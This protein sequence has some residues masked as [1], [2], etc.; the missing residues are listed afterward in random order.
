LIVR[1]GFDDATTGSLILLLAPFASYLPAEH[2]R[3]SG[4][5]AAVATGIVLSRRSRFFIGPETRMQSSSTW[6]LLTFILNGF[7]FLLIGL[8][9]PTIVA[10]LEPHVRDYA[11]TAAVLCAVVIVVRLA[12]VAL[13]TAV[14]HLRPGRGP[15]TSWAA[16][17]V[18]GW[19]G[20]RGIV[21]LAAALAL[22]YTLGDEPFPQREETIFFTVC[23]VFVTLVV[24]GLTLGPLIEW[25][26]VTE[27]SR[28]RQAESV[29]R[30]RALEAAAAHLRRARET[31]DD[32]E[33]ELSGRI[34]D[35]YEQRIGVL[36]GTSGKD[37][38]SARVEN[39]IDRRLQREALEAERVAVMRM[40]AEGQVPDEMFRSI[41]YDLDLASLRLS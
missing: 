7:A 38:Q 1:L 25:L 21:S 37:E 32:A 39:E 31:G 23:V 17:L 3:A 2:F 10:E 34:L 36:T 19:S 13:T 8:Q 29:V 11:V 16:T 18:I 24:Q 5:L 14:Q 28:S 40:R 20:M 26:G 15:Q 22:P 6:R 4:V 33:L 41:E 35:E 9:L 12:W 27:H 30:I